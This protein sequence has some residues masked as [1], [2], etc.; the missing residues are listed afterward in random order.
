MKD[1]L[2]AVK[3][4]SDENR[5]RIFCMLKQRPLCVCEIYAVLDI[6]LS[7]LSQHLKLMKSAGLI[8]DEKDG[9]WVIYSLN[10][11]NGLVTRMMDFLDRELG[12]DERILRDRKK[13]SGLS[14]D[15]CCSALQK[16]KKR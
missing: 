5:M 2:S 14:R 3:A 12:A 15:I 8:D 10:R 1:F 9:R 6:A 16:G 11:K 13:V 4:L 7:T